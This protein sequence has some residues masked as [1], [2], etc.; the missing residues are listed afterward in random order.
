MSDDEK[1]I[2]LDKFAYSIRASQAVLQYGVGAMID[3][4]TQTLMT[5]AAECWTGGKHIYDERLAKALGV[6]YFCSPG[7]IDEEKNPIRMPYVRF[8]EWYFCPKCRKLQRLES[9]ISEYEEKNRRR[10]NESEQEYENRIALALR[11]AEC[12]QNLVVA[13]IVTACEHGHINDF[14]WEEWTHKKDKKCPDPHLKIKTSPSGSEGLDGLTIECSCGAK[15]TLRGAFGK[16]VF[17]TLDEITG[18]RNFVCRGNHPQNL[19]K[20]ECFLYPRTMQR[21]SSSIYFPIIRTSLVIPPYADRLNKKIEKSNEFKTYNQIVEKLGKAHMRNHFRKSVDEIATEIGEEKDLVEKILRRKWFGSD[22]EHDILDVKYRIAEY[23]ALSGQT[24]IEAKK[25]SDFLR[26]KMDAREY[27]LPLV[28][29]ISLIT[30]VRVVNA[31]IGFSRINPVCRETDDGFVAVKNSNI[32]WYP[33]CEVFGEGI[34][35]EFDRNGI[36]EWIAKNPEINNRIR[37]INKKYGDSLIGKNNPRS[38]TPKFVML[39]TLSHLLIKRLSF[40][41]GYSIASLSERIYSSEESEGRNMAGIFI[42]TSSGDSEGTLGGLVRQGMPDSFPDLFR[43]AVFDA[44][45]CSNDPVCILSKGQGHES[46]NLAA[47]HTCALLPE[48]CC[49]ERNSLLDRGLIVGTFENKKMGLFHDLVN[50]KNR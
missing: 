38:I 7:G 5:A 36:D 11:C 23:D 42:Y 14:P 46:L 6:S 43:K 15:E 31:L 41:C 32:K 45:M 13:R 40:E 34:F 28:E 29:S 18:E 12:N 10:W 4:P 25:G 21:G 17:K 9:W 1:R 24:T 44:E 48:T 37:I 39:H 2:E 47:C 35:I 49:E 8:P 30:K 3:F 19:K 20:G 26:K 16:D 22:D 50:P 33:A 27:H